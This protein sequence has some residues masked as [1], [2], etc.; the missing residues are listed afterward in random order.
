[1]L[2][3]RGAMRKPF[4]FASILMF[5]NHNIRLSFSTIVLDKNYDKYK[6]PVDSGKNHLD[7]KISVDLSEI[8]EIEEVKGTMIIKFTFTRLWADNRINFSTLNDS[9][10]RI[11]PEE[12]ELIWLPWTIF[13]N[14]KHKESLLSSD[15]PNIYLAKK[16]PSKELNESRMI[17]FYERELI[18]EFMCDYDMF[19]FPFDSQTCGMKLYQNEDQVQLVLQGLAYRGPKNLEQYSVTGLRMCHSVFEVNE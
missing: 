18:G 1:M 15:K 5:Y 14:L 10:T 11:L 7:L 13:E 4:F 3:H 17:V 19:W 12:K 6:H 9:Q 8:R 2:V 16:V